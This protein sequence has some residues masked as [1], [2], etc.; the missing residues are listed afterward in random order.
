MPAQVVTLARLRED[1]ELFDLTD[2]NHPQS[3]A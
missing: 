3:P 1:T 2:G